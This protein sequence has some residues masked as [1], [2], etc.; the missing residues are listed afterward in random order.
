M[1]GRRAPERDDHHRRK[2]A[3]RPAKAYASVEEERAKE[4]A[5]G[6]EHE[7]TD[8]YEEEHCED[9]DIDWDAL[10]DD[11]REAAEE[12]YAA[13]DAAKTREKAERRTMAQ[14]RAVVK[15][16]KTSRGFFRKGDKAKGGGKGKHGPGPCFVCGGA[17][18]KRD[19]PRRAEPAIQV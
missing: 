3:R 14:A 8:L 6:P 18:Q 10:D 9:G 17:H 4:D 11:E 13:I 2:E 15:E 12:A 7:E 16:I 19:C 1:G 5:E